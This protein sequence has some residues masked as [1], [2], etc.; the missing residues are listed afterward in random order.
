MK[1]K[2]KKKKKEEEEEEKR[3]KNDRDTA[4]MKKWAPVPLVTCHLSQA[5]K[6]DREVPSLHFH[7]LNSKS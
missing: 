5:A 1:K 7:H 6:E 3:K 2:R 4:T